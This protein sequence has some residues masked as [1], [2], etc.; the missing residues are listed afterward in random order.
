MKDLWER[1]I[2][3]VIRQATDWE[4]VFVMDQTH[5]GLYKEFSHVKM[6]KT[7]KSIKNGEKTLTVTL[8]KWTDT[9]PISVNITNQRKRKI[10]NN[11]RVAKY[12]A[13]ETLI[14]CW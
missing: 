5:K 11:T 10:A 8:E 14:N 12:R 1:D 7:E 4:K 6:E 13:S 2:E 3:R 9:W